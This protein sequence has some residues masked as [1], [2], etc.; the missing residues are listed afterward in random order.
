MVLGGVVLVPSSTASVI[1]H[2]LRLTA[3]YPIPSRSDIFVFLIVCFYVFI[4]VF[5]TCFKVEVLKTLY[6]S[7]L[8]INLTFAD[9][10]MVYIDM[11]LFGTFVQAS[12]G[13]CIDTLTYN[14]IKAK[15]R[16]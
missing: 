10:K 8:I 3:K 6:W 15:V 4:R 5:I 16:T 9:T 12:L 11:L 2:A 13:W 7:D 1:C 14:G